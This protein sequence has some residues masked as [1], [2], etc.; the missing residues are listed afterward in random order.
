MASGSGKVTL[1]RRGGEIVEIHEEASLLI[2]ETKCL[3]H[4]L[5]CIDRLHAR[6][7]S[8]SNNEDAIATLRYP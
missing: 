8:L 1:E 7:E 3:D 2:V 6:A 5:I 4:F